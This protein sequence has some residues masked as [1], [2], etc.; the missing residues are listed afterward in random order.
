MSDKIV[1]TG[2]EDLVYEPSEKPSTATQITVAVN[3]PAV[4][5]PLP[6]TFGPQNLA[7]LAREIVM[8][9]REIPDILATFK[10]TPA[11]Y[12]RVKSLPYFQKALDTLSIEWNSALSTA[13]RIKVGAAAI[14]ENGMPNLGA[15]MTNPSE[16]YTAQ[17]EAGKLFAK[18]AG[19]GEP[20][21]GSGGGERFTISI[22]LGADTVLRYEKDV[23]PKAVEGSASPVPQDPKEN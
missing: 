3:L 12:E 23:T 16:P 22:N 10:L 21:T 20:A 14:L 15:R 2:L 1:N 18:L 5:D 13:Q 19:V 4:G 8:S 9:I 7:A 6:E 11:Q 17:I